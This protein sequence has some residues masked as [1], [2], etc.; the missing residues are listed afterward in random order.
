M[1]AVADS[2][3]ALRVGASGRGQLEIAPLA[4]AVHIMG[5]PA[6]EL[7][8][9]TTGTDSDW[10]VKLIDV[11]PNDVPEGAAQGAK[12]SVAGFELPI[13]IE[14]FRGR[15]LKSFAQPAPLKAGKVERYRWGCPT[16]I[17]C[18]CRVTGSWCRSSRACSRSTIAIRRPTWT[19]SCTRSPATI[20]RRRR[21]C[22][23]A[24]PL[25]VVLP[26]VP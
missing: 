26:V 24:V 16:S 8:A 6:V 17:T 22:G 15:Y 2:R 14:I 4:K 19:T 7:F 5:A 12:P 21:A 3:P 11:Y 20:R 13:G 25:E 10:V 23:L 18:S 9:S 1:E